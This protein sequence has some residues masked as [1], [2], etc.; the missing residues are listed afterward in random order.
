MW[1]SWITQ[2][3]LLSALQLVGGV[4]G[5]NVKGR[6]NDPRETCRRFDVA[7]T[8]IKKQFRHNGIKIIKTVHGP[9]KRSDV[10]RVCYVTLPYYPKPERKTAFLCT[11][12]IAGFVKT[13]PN[14]TLK[15]VRPSDPGQYQDL[16]DLKTCNPRLKVLV[17]TGVNNY[18][19]RNDS[20]M[21]SILVNTSLGRRKFVDG[22]LA[23]L[24]QYGFDGLDLDWEYP[25][26]YKNNNPT[27]NAT[28]DKKNFALLLKE[29][30]IA[31]RNTSDPGY[32]KPLLLSVPVSA[33]KSYIDAGYDIRNISKFADLVNLMCYNYHLYQPYRNYT[34]HNSPLFKNQD[35]LKSELISWKDKILFSTADVN[36]TVHYLIN[37]S[38]AIKKLNVGLPVFGRTFSLADPEKHDFLAPATG[39]GPGIGNGFIEYH[40]VCKFEKQNGTT[41][42]YHNKT[43]APYVYNKTVWVAY[44]EKRAIT[45]KV[46]WVVSNKYGGVMTYALNFDDINNTCQAG[47]YP[48]HTL[49][50]DLLLNSTTLP[51]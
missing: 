46:E 41:R 6:T 45:A 44:N 28:G 34:R 18:N 36:W 17:T 14:G 30:R 29:L 48:I 1:L 3:A 51:K 23:F 27:N 21:F 16:L 33:T 9:Y 38:L 31:F 8:C 50:R 4:D 2:V 12:L 22:A 7:N 11:H 35:E 5:D 24:R 19:N 40:W 25:G 49:I 43:E 15:M 26:H 10:R 32:C 37:Q 42:M 20:T 47:N 39:P 13:L